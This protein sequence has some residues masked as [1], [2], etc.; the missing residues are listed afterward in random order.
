MH[1]ETPFTQEERAALRRSMIRAALS[2]AKE[3]VAPSD[4]AYVQDRWEEE[5]INPETGAY[6]PEADHPSRSWQGPEVEAVGDG[7]IREIHSA[8]S[9]L[10]EKKK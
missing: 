1:A 2:A 6:E 7:V 9:S 10:L 3:A 8:L 5:F 4:G